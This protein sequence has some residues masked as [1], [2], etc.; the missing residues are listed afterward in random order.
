MATGMLRISQIESAQR[1]VTLRLEGR[2]VGPWVKELER[3]CEMLVMDGRKITL[4]LEA[5]EFID[6]N[7]VALLAALTGKGVS[8]TECSSF[9]QEQLKG[10]AFAQDER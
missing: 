5:V 10:V 2:L 7:G 8:L 1:S 6:R 9:L 3:A 4:D